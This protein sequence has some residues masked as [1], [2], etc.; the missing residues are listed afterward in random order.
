MPPRDCIWAEWQQWS[1]CSESCAGGT[2]TKTRMKSET[3]NVAGS[4][5]GNSTETEICNQQECSGKVPLNWDFTLQYTYLFVEIS[6]N[7]VSS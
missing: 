6:Y 7:F 4:C 2:R 1:T 5:A 3:E